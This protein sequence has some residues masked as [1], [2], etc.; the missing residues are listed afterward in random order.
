MSCLLVYNI[1]LCCIIL[2]EMSNSLMSNRFRKCEW[3]R[4][5]HTFNVLEC[6]PFTAVCFF[7]HCGRFVDCTHTNSLNVCVLVD[8]PFIYYGRS[9]LTEEHK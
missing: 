7:Q 8:F 3:M 5:Y 1:D 9:F 2:N 4:L 6:H